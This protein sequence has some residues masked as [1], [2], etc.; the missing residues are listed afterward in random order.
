MGRFKSRHF[1]Y[2]I[3]EAGEAIEYLVMPFLI[4][5]D[6]EEPATVRYPYEVSL[7]G[8]EVEEIDGAVAFARTLVF[9]G[10]QRL[11]KNIGIGPIV[12]TGSQLL[13][14]PAGTIGIM[15]S[16]KTFTIPAIYLAHFTMPQAVLLWSGFDY[17]SQWTRDGFAGFC[18]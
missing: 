10:E 1:A 13:R 17:K 7:Y 11:G 5:L 9:S 15:F 8:E 16:K 18:G 3:W 2:R 6:P 12:E 14:R 4:Q